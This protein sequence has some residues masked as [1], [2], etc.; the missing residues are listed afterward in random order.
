MEAFQSLPAWAQLFLA[1][2]LGGILLL[3]NIGWLMQARGWLE[4][5]RQEQL[6]RRSGRSGPT[7]RAATGQASQPPAPR[8][9]SP[10]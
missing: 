10:R 3:L 9:Q 8:E 7:Q 5:A 4:R 1:L 2:V 6:A